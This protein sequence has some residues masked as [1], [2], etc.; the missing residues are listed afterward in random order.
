[1][2]SWHQVWYELKQTLTGI[3]RVGDTG[4][5][6]GYHSTCRVCV[7]WGLSVGLSHCEITISLSI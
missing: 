3:L 4:V 5:G 2:D 6:I 7:I 1:M